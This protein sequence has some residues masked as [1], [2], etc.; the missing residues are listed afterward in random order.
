MRSADDEDAAPRFL[1][2][3]WRER[4]E[5][6]ANDARVERDPRRLGRQRTP[7]ATATARSR[8]CEMLTVSGWRRP[9]ACRRA[10]ARP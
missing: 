4:A 5:D 1:A 9:S 10:S 7:T 8:M 2:G 6:L 3:V